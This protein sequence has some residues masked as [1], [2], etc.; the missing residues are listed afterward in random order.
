MKDEMD[1]ETRLLWVG[2]VVY[3]IAHMPKWQFFRG[4]MHWSAYNAHIRTSVVHIVRTGL[5]T[6]EAAA[7]LADEALRLAE[8]PS[9]A[10]NAENLCRRAL[11]ILEK[12]TDPGEL[13]AA[14]ILYDATFVY[15]NL[16]KWE[17]M[18]ECRK[19]A[20]PTFE[21]MAEDDPEYIVLAWEL[22][23]LQAVKT[24]LSEF[25]K[26]IPDDKEAG[27]DR[28]MFAFRH[29]TENT[30]SLDYAFSYRRMG[31][32]FTAIGDSLRARKSFEYALYEFERGWDDYLSWAEFKAIL[33]LMREDLA[34]LNKA[35]GEEMLD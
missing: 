20:L 28:A 12:A 9:S 22:R 1:D 16:G 15:Y 30:G 2:R 10:S 24:P 5:D 33:R 8:V 21:R 25:R 18:R 6:L 3:A 4:D 32:L 26:A 13:S 7:L 29:Q 34:S 14:N 19:R 17:E 35:R 27:Y 31:H 23:R 11:Q